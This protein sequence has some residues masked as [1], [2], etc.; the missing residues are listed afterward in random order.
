[1]PV[2]EKEPE[3]WGKARSRYIGGSVCGLVVFDTALETPMAGRPWA[4]VR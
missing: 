4:P 2:N 3:G 1:M